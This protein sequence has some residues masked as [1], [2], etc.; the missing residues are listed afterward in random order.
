[1]EENRKGSTLY[2]V[3]GVAT[4]VVAIIG[5]TFAYF[6]AQASATGDKIQ[7]GTSDVGSALSIKVDRVLFGAA[8]PTDEEGKKFANLVPAQLTVD[9]EGIAKAVNNKCF[10]SGY[11]GCHLYK[12]TA[13][14]TQTIE[15]ADILLQSFTVD[16]TDKS[17]WKFVVFTGTETT[18]SEEEGGATTY[19]VNSIIT[20]TT[21]EN[22]NDTEAT[23]GSNDG[24]S[25]LGYNINK[26]AEGTKLGMTANEDRVYYLLIY[27]A[28]NNQ[29]QNDNTSHAETSATG[30]YSGS[31]V[32]NAAG[33]KVV[34]NFNATTTIGG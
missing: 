12:I 20:G 21:A 30:T 28:D 25:S 22:F 2:V 32:L 13:R 17:A 27:L 29:V 7:G 18:A 1:M 15:A 9:N 34:A 6:S 5:A 23:K 11:T 31:V 19:T 3:L 26:K 33:G 24:E 4:L 10:A 16:A 14:S 8:A